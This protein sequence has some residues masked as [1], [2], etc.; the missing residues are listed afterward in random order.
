MTFE[1]AFIAFILNQKVIG[2]GFQQQIGVL[3]PNGY[4]AYPCGYFTEYENGYK[5]IASGATL[6][7]IDIQEAMILDPNGVPVARDTEDLRPV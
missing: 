6:H 4:Y 7:K 2:W 3:L 5:L 1:E